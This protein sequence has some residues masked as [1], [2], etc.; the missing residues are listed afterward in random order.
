MKHYLLALFC[1]A[2]CLIF[3]N[4]QNCRREELTNGMVATLLAGSLSAGQTDPPTVN[5]LQTNIV[6]LTTATMYNRYQFVSVVVRYTC[7]N[8][9]ACPSGMYS[10]YQWSR[11]YYWGGGGGGGGTRGRVCT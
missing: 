11:N 10:Y 9:I 6:C 4:A 8:S 3:S 7:S 5:V 1:S 2:S